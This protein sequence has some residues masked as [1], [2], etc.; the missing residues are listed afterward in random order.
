M[1]SESEASA[2]S[3]AEAIAETVDAEV[4]R[5]TAARVRPVPQVEPAAPEPRYFNRELSWLAFN[6]RVLEE[7]CNP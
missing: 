3:E 2:A 1:N 4:I 5:E 7:A 6:R